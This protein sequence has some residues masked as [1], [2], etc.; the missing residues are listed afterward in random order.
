MWPSITVWIIH[1]LKPFLTFTTQDRDTSYKNSFLLFIIAQ[2][3][4]SFLFQNEEQI[5]V[6]WVWNIWNFLSN[7]Q[8][9]TWICRNR[10]KKNEFSFIILWN[11]LSLVI[12]MFLVV[13]GRSYVLSNPYS[14]I[15]DSKVSFLSVIG[16]LVL[17]EI[18]L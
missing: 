3:A 9:A 4:C 15:H 7:L 10:S 2:M 8:E 11:G 1:V 13:H 18:L 17:S 6:F 12:N 16:N 14:F 5:L